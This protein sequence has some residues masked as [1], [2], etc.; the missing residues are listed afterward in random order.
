MEFIKLINKVNDD[1]IVINNYNNRRKYNEK[2][3]E[4]SK[5]ESL[6]EIMEQINEMENETSQSQ[7]TSMRNYSKRKLS[8]I[9][10]TS[11]PNHEP[12]LNDISPQIVNI[13]NINQTSIKNDIRVSN[14][15]NNVKEDDNNNQAMLN[16]MAN[17]QNP[18]ANYN[19]Q[20][21]TFN[22]AFNDNDNNNNNGMF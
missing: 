14:E 8:L 21:S 22:N 11:F 9:Q 1:V 4:S 15:P 18:F 17:N 10:Q 6:S 5:Y 2:S 13:N 12:E 7:D 16:N 20:N 19:P 3:F